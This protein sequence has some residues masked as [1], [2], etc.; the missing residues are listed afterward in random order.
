MRIF[1][2]LSLLASCWLLPPG[3]VLAETGLPKEFSPLSGDLEKQMQELLKAAEKWRGLTY[4]Q[5]VPCGSLD[6]DR[7]KK[8]VL[9]M[10]KEELPA[11]KMNALETGL[12]AFGLIPQDMKLATYYPELLTSQIGGFY[13]PKKKYLALIQ[14]KEGMFDKATRDQLGAAMAD[15]MEQTALVHELTHALQ[16]QHFDLQKF[17]I[18]T[19]LADAA[20]ARTGLVEGDATLTM[21]DFVLGMRVEDVPMLDKMMSALADD[22]KQ[23]FAAM[24]NMP[25]SKEMAAAPAWFRDT[26][27][28]SYLQGMTFCASVKHLGGQ[29]L[30]DYA[31]AKDP[32]RSTEQILHPEKWHS[33]RDDPVVIEFPDLAQE[34]P[35]YKRVSEGQLGELSIRT[36]L[37]EAVKDDKKAATAAAGWGG[38]QFAVYQKDNNA[39][40][41][42]IT[43]W[44]SNQDCK[45]FK[46][47][48]GTL[49]QDWTI[50]NCRPSRVVVI[51]GKL[52]APELEAVKTKLAAAKA[53]VPDNKAI[54][55]ASLGIKGQPAE[56]QPEVAGGNMQ[57]SIE[58]LLNGKDGGLDLAKLM[59][60]PNIQKMAEGML[61]GN[62][63]DG[64]LDLGALMQNP[65]VQEMAKNMLSQER[66]KGQLSDDGRTYTNAQIGI[67]FKLPDA[68]NDWQFQKQAP[69]M[70]AAAANNEKEGLQVTLAAQPMPMAIDVAEM[71]DMMEIGFKM[72][73]ENY[74]KIEIGPGEWN[75]K[76]GCNAQYE[77]TL[78]GTRMR[79]VQRLFTA[80]STMVVVSAVVPTDKW[81]KAEKSINAVF[82]GLK[83]VAPKPAEKKEPLKE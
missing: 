37:R 12:K 23:L 16:D 19:P 64:G 29:K 72:A 33:Q 77:G 41:L 32:P 31:F 78:N 8:Q 6:R 25:G 73:V 35:G 10:F 71:G 22:P 5:P 61:K 34:L 24:P 83:F 48:A 27:L 1:L 63:D 65:M 26:L 45:E 28:F 76:K 43:E 11:D 9:D 40:L 18:E 81:D 36:L 42:W 30:L 50:D 68:Q 46:E 4:K 75:G 67:E 21:Y 52:Q 56:K 7:L 55:L 47:A 13:E 82:S 69:P 57:K 51:R 54:D 15:K 2:L 66:P 44:D 49:G 62:K 58:E 79:F 80:G 70:L 60:D 20:A 3:R 53:Q 74:K 38:D 59:K 17:M 14:G 39:V